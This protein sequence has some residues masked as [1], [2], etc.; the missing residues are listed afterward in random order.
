MSEKDCKKDMQTTP[1]P[2][3]KVRRNVVIFKAL[4][5][6]SGSI[7]AQNL[8][9]HC[10]RYLRVFHEGISIRNSLE[11]SGPAAM[12][13]MAFRK[14]HLNRRPKRGREGQ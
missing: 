5:G 1:F 2:F 10:Q 4:R 7:D 9:V 13:W 11:E 14:H 12:V 3:E 6:E 8:L